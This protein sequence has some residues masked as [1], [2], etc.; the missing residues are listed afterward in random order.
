MEVLLQFRLEIPL[1]HCLGDWVGN[2]GNSQ[3][4]ESTSSLLDVHALHRRWE[5]PVGLYVI[6][7]GTVTITMDDRFGDVLSR[8]RVEPGSLLGLPA[9]IANVSSS[10]SA[11]AS[12]GANV[13]LFPLKDF[14]RLMPTEPG[15]AIKVWL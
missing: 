7:S 2:S 12:A 14:A 4:P 11:E 1:D 6:H 10:L 8:A 9:V 15:L 3:W 5:S 13:S